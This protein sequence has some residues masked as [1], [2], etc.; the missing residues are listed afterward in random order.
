[1]KYLVMKGNKNSL[2]IVFGKKYAML[3]DYETGDVNKQYSKSDAWNMLITC[4]NL[5]YDVLKIA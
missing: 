5:K 1:M 3:I 4:R 2:K